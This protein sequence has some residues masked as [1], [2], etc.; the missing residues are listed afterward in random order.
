MQSATNRDTYV[1]IKFENIE[2]GHE[3]NFDKHDGSKISDFDV[4]YDYGS[5]LHYSRTAF[6]VDGSDTIIPLKVE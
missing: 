4:P 6:S 1:K 3:H 2:P 5:V